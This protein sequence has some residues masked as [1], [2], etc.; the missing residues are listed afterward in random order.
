[1]SIASTTR[2]DVER[3]AEIWERSSWAGGGFTHTRAAATLRALL[4][5][6]DDLHISLVAKEA[7]A[8]SALH[9]AWAERDAA[10]AERD[11]AQTK[12]KDFARIAYDAERKAAKA[13]IDATALA[14]LDAMEIQPVLMAVQEWAISTGKAR[15]L[16]RCWIVGTFTPDM[17][18]QQMRD[19]GLSD[20]DDPAECF[21]AM[22]YERDTA[23]AECEAHKARADRYDT[24]AACASILRA[25]VER[26]REALSTAERRLESGALRIAE[27]GDARAAYGLK[28]WAADA[29]AALA[30]APSHE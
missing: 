10:R 22:R 9:D 14:G 20:D 11:D 25:E 30:G 17:L 12:V 6:R 27:L 1:M 3:L 2:E 4:D 16:L 24:E 29:R 15:D 8:Q 21:L 18:P 23:R 7:A 28:E 19:L 13:N 26:V 5:E